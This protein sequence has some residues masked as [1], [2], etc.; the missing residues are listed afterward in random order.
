MLALSLEGSPPRAR[1]TRGDEIP[2]EL[3]R[4]LG[5]NIAPGRVVRL[6]EN[7]ISIPL[8]RLLASRRWLSRT[9]AAYACRVEVTSELEE[10]LAR[11]S[12]EYREVQKILAVGGSKPVSEADLDELLSG[13]RFSRHL[14]NFQ[15]RDLCKILGLS[16]GANFSVPGAGKTTVSYAC[17]EAERMRGRVNRLLVVAPLSAFEA[18]SEE[19]LVCF[20][21]APSVR[22]LTDVLPFQAEVLL[23]NYQRLR[24]RFDLLAEWMA[25]GRCH[26]VL[27]EAHRMKR[28][29]DGQWGAACLELAHYAVRR[30]ILTG[31][32]APQHPADFDALVNFLWPDNGSA[33]LPSAARA[34]DPPPDAMSELSKRLG[35][36]FAR[37]KKNELGL[38]DPIL[39][40]EECEMKPIQAEIY[41]HLRTRMRRAVKAGARERA[42]LSRLGEVVM[43]L[44]EAAVNPGLLAPAIGG[45]TKDLIWPP[46]A[47]DDGSPLA[48]QIR[49][50]SE[51]E[52]PIKFEKL[53]VQIS[54]NVAN[55]RKT[56]IW[57]NFIANFEAIGDLLA[58]YNPAKIYGAV[59]TNADPG[60]DVVTRD[61]ELARFRSNDDC[62]VLIA[63]P[64]AMSEGVS[65]HED[66]HDAIYV[67]RTFNAG[68]YLQSLDRIHRLGLK[69]GTE[70]RITFLVC[71]DTIDEAVGE[72]VKI[73]ATRLGELLSDPALTT[74]AL[75]DEEMAYGQWIDPGDSA[76]LF[77][78]L[79]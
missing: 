78:H 5:R 17:Y 40:V 70:T 69:A 26:L 45:S 46:I 39:R 73:K 77:A 20:S 58:P 35:P 72:R 1:I 6:S 11:G 30:D 41:S 4:A 48:E 2:E 68:Q 57:T 44:L 21:P 29:H 27:D 64:A 31:T 76:V 50:Y 79:S 13:S 10:I 7:E 52:V 9:L 51:L 56:L 38:D 47:A 34:N 66:C 18:W 43:Y 59:P 49:R 42:E 54:E 74:M 19:A 12:E 61:S 22:Q 65:L 14:L 32:P 3:W 37:T 24:S 15:R 71:R 8:E 63:N 16:H 62:A 23:V 67:D 53:A 28:G 36:F 60:S 75:P 55:G 33:I 25:E